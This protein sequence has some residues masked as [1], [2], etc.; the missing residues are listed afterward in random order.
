MNPNGLPAGVAV[1]AAQ[2]GANRR[3]KDASVSAHSRRGTAL[4]R[5]RPAPTRSQITR[6]TSLYSR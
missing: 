5:P 1:A 6:P 2:E 3:A 4:R